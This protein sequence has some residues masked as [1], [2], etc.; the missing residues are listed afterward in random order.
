MFKALVLAGTSM[1]PGSSLRAPLPGAQLEPGGRAC[2]RTWLNCSCGRPVLQCF[3]IES[4]IG[5]LAQSRRLL[6][7]PLRAAQALSRTHAVS[8]RRGCS[9]GAAY[10]VIWVR[11]RAQFRRSSI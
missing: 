5:I 1:F 9:A 6:G 10:A 4:G 2:H 7:S 3:S 8:W 11:Y